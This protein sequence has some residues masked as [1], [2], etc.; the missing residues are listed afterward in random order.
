MN[1]RDGGLNFSGFVTNTGEVEGLAQFLLVLQAWTLGLELSFYLI[2]PFIVRRS[3]LLVLLFAGSLCGRLFAIVSGFGLS[4]PWTYRFFPFEL[5]LFIGGVFSHQL[6]LRPVSALVATSSKKNMPAY[7][8][9]FCIVTCALYFVIPLPEYVK[10]PGLLA[11]LF[12]SLPFL[13]FF[14][15]KAN[16]TN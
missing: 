8:V 11:L 2:A 1:V 12:V 5:A 7:V 3:F 4:D 13:L 6:L 9:A 14:S 15:P 16:G 10:T